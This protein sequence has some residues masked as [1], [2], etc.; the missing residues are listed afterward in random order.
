MRT[1]NENSDLKWLHIV[2]ATWLSRKSKTMDMVKRSGV[3]RC[4]GEEGRLRRLNKEML[5]LWKHLAGI[6]MTASCP[7][8]CVLSCLSHVPPF[9][10]PWTVAHQAPLSR[11]SLGK[12]IGVGSMLSSR[13]SC[14]PRDQTQVSNVSCIGRQ[15]LYHHCHLGSHMASYTCPNP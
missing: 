8:V 12:N 9:V 6:A 3:A 11:S 4:W 7:H 10:T 15:V 2:V 1:L 13:G 5:G 14:Q